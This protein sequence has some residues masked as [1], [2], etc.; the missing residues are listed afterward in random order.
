MLLGIDVG[1]TFTDAVLIDRGE[2]VKY[3]KYTTTYPEVL[4]GIIGALDKV[5]VGINIENIERVTISS[6]IVTNALL[7][8]KT[9]PLFLAVMPGPGLNVK[10]KFPIKPYIV[11]GYVDHR[12]KVLSEPSFNEVEVLKEIEGKKNA[13]VSGKF[14]V[15]NQINER[16]LRRSLINLGVEKIYCGAKMSSELNF[17]RRTNSACFSAMVTNNFDNFIK[18]VK[19][20]LDKRGIKVPIQILKADGCSLPI[21]KVC[22]KPVEA[23]FTGP[24]ASV[25]GIEALGVPSKKAISL[26]VGGTT[27][28]IAFWKGG[29][30]L[31]SKKGIKIDKYFTA[32]QGF[33]MKS[34]GIGGDSV[35]RRDGAFTVGP[36]RIGP[37]MSLGGNK[38]TLTDALL[39]L[40][41]I[42]YGDKEKAKIGFLSLVKNGETEFEIAN[43]FVDIA[44]LTLKNAIEAMIEELSLQPVYEVNDIFNSKRFEPKTLIGVGGGAYGLIKELGKVMEIDTII[45]T[46][47]IVANAIGAAVAKV[48]TE[49]S[50]R[51][52]TTEGYYTIADGNIKERCSSKF[53]L[54]EA[55]KLLSDFLLVK[56][57]EL[58]I[59]SPKLEVNSLEEFFTIHDNV[60][61]G[62]IINLRM[63]VK[64]GVLTSVSCKEA[65]F[66]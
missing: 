13:V 15:R 27:T 55:E 63:Q 11:K 42:D 4:D 66:K 61:T 56:A 23:I 36:D 46:G 1:G 25:L 60:S 16:K 62:K 3:A 47:S 51:V 29:R 7:E 19:L 28:D 24:A 8:G 59:A 39:I 41:L 40:G 9:E 43:K 48:T 12:G 21:D 45:P 65:S 57:S 26:D 35:L 32:V 5:I 64:H 38:A 22:E 49:A 58:K 54:K 2:V 18:Q 14:A 30:P 50:L 31:E 34:V 52:D 53:G 33:F 10:D 20:S 17:I 37:A 6:T 44:V